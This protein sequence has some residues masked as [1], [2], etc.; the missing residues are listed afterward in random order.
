[1]TTAAWW[2]ALVV[3]SVAM[4]TVPLLPA[5]RE[6]THPT[7]SAALRVEPNYATEAAFFAARFRESVAAWQA[8]GLPPAPPPASWSEMREPII[9]PGGL[10]LEERV[11]AAAP[12]YVDGDLESRVECAFKALLAS[13]SVRLAANS[14]IT[15]WVHAERSLRLGEGSV[16][17]RRASCGEA[18]ELGTGCS[19]ERLRGRSIA[20]GTYG[21]FPTDRNVVAT[22]ADLSRVPNAA[23]RAEGVYRVNG[24]CTLP[25]AA[26]FKGSLIVTGSLSVGADSIFE[27]DIKARKG[28]VVGMGARIHGAITSETVVH[29]EE[30][31]FVKGPVVAET[32]VWLDAGV[33]LGS[34][35]MPTTVTA[36]NII[37]TAGVVAH[38][39]VWA[40]DAGIVWS[41]A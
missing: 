31:A 35:R 37:V 4:L 11:A 1:M 8:Q 13:G 39:T 21:Y 9:V 7:D 16:A 32:D 10:C 30:G 36:E 29:I 14:E 24:D 41:P 23:R 19:F 33:E 12:V 6:W 34:E 18:L 2:L 38:G 20:F 27:G 5:L 22:P 17:L 15:E 40:R 25:A 26:H 28:V 3:L